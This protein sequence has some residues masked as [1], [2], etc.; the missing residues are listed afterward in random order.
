[1]KLRCTGLFEISYSVMCKFFGRFSLSAFIG[2][3]LFSLSVGCSSAHDAPAAEET[4]VS[5]NVLCLGNSITRHEYAASVEWYSD[6]GMAASKPENDY[7]HVLESLLNGKYPGSTVTP[8]NIAAWERSLSD[9]IDGFIGEYV[10]DK[11]IIVVRLGENVTAE[12]A[13]APA[14]QKLVSWCVALRNMSLSPEHSGS[15]RL[16]RR[17]SLRL[18]VSMTSRTIRF[19]SSIFPKII[20][21]SATSFIASTAELT[22]YQRIS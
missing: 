1:M 14:L 10:R 3:L 8:L 19:R 6:W 21:R 16:R 17:Q 2:V 15:R 20:R 11:D 13:F 7:C 12:R 5:Y 9:D 18:P 22:V 4:P